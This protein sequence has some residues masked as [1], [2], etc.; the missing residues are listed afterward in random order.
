[1]KYPNLGLHSDLTPCEDRLFDLINKNF[2][3]IDSSW[4]LSIEGVVTTLPAIASEGEFYV[5]K[6]ESPLSYS[7]F[8]YLKN[9]W[10]ELNFSEGKW[11]W[12]K[13]KENFFV[14]ANNAIEALANVLEDFYLP[15]AVQTI[16]VNG[17]LN[18]SI[19]AH[20]MIKVVGS[21]LYT[22]ANTLPFNNSPK[23]GAR[24]I[25]MGTNSSLQV[26]FTTNDNDGGL[27][28]NQDFYATRFASLTVVYDD[29]LKRYFEISRTDR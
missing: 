1:M 25:I 28:L 6:T 5:L 27:I 20:Q 23:N 13:D 12:D 14:Y 7:L 3:L 19:N 17:K 8:I 29:H 18:L 21:S 2:L 22:N 16:A 9:S 15:S 24:I 11:F 26:V 4:N 10:Q